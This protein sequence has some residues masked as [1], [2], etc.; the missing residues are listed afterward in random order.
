MNPLNVLTLASSR[1]FAV[2]I[3]TTIILT[4][5]PKIMGIEIPEEKAAE[6]AEFVVGAITVISSALMV[7]MGLREHKDGK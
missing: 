5:A 2:M 7:S 1:R 3:L 4:Q 6:Y